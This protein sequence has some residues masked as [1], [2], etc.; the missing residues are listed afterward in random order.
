MKK[1]RKRIAGEKENIRAG[2]ASLPFF[3]HD[4]VTRHGSMMPPQPNYGLLGKKIL[5]PLARRRRERKG[6]YGMKGNNFPHPSM[7]YVSCEMFLLCIHVF[8]DGEWVPSYRPI[9]GKY[10]FSF[11]WFSVASGGTAM[12]IP[13]SSLFFALIQSKIGR[14]AKGGGE[15]EGISKKSHRG[16]KRRR[17]NPLILLFLFPPSDFEAI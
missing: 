9:R 14:G 8:I 11:R 16:K 4:D 10:L 17:R 5:Q 1:E 12:H 7:Y 6:T 13:P 3:C 15:E 2:A